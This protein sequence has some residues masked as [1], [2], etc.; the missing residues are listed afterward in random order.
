MLFYTF[1]L[2]F[3]GQHYFIIIFEKLFLDY[4]LYR[5]FKMIKMTLKLSI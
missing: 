3:I 2:Y 4:L 1:L 5:D